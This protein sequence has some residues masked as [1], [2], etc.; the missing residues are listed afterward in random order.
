MR[1]A[2]LA[3]L[4][5]GCTTSPV[6][7]DVF[8]ITVDTLRRD[9]VSAYNAASPVQTPAIDALADDS[10]RFT[11]AFSPISVTGPAFASAM[12]GLNPEGHGVMVNLF[13]NG[14]PLDESHTTL[15]ERMKAASYTTGAF[16]SAFTLRPALGLNQ[17]FDVYNSGGAKNRTGDITAAVFSSWLRVQE[18]P[19]FSWYHSFDPHG[20]VSRHLNESDL[21]PELEREPGLLQHFP[22]YQ[23]IEDITEPALFEALYA[24][25][26]AFADEQVAR[27]VS[28]IKASGRYDDALIIFFADH[29]EGFR[30]RALWYDHGAY[31]HAEQTWIPL[32][33]KLPKG[34]SAGTTDDRLASLTDVLPTVAAISKLTGV[35]RV[36]GQSL[37]VEGGGHTVVVSES[38]HC[39]RVAVLECSPKGGAG[40]VIAVRS[41]EQTAVSESRREGERVLVYD[42]RADPKEWTAKPVDAHPEVEAVLSRVRTDRRTRDYPPLPDLAPI[43]ADDAEAQQLKSLGYIE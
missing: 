24:R 4:A 19:V 37:L 42:R 18:G 17:G 43:A 16:V 33:V 15:A 11:D 10:I 5:V 40:K 25:G 23:Q 6:R 21:H 39:K 27:V 30:E 3:V 31:P 29:G 41:R 14:A 13:R 32:L 1:W 35:G 36:D 22:R 34:A 9:H 8:L 28:A 7:P 26:V 2:I 38:S 12:T 20:P